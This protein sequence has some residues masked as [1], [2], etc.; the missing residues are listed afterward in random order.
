MPTA[1]MRLLRRTTEQC[2]PAT[3]AIRR[4]L[5]DT[6]ASVGQLLTPRARHMV[7]PPSFTTGCSIS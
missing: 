1:T 4:P 3:M 2:S 7:M 6:T 5:G